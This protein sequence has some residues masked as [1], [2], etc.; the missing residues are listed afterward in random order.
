M[1]ANEWAGQTKTAGDVPAKGCANTV[2]LQSAHITNQPS[3]THTRSHRE[4]PAENEKL[5]SKRYTENVTFIP[6]RTSRRKIK[7]ELT[8]IQSE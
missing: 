5:I 7:G 4:S 6:Q 2:Q 1:C 3:N 8:M